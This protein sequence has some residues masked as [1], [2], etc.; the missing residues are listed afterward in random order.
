MAVKTYK[1]KNVQNK[2]VSEH[3]KYSEFFCPGSATLKLDPLLP[4]WL[5]ALIY[6]LGASKAVITSGYR[7]PDYSVKVGGSRTDRHTKGMAADVIFYDKAGKIIPPDTVCCTAEALGFIGGIAKI[8]ATATHIDTR[9]MSSKYWGDESKGST[10]SIWNQ[11]SGC[12]SFY[13]WFGKTRPKETMVTYK[14]RKTSVYRSAPF[15]LSAT[16]LGKLKKGAT[17]KVVKGGR[18]EYGGVTF[19]KVKIGNGYYWVNKR[20]LSK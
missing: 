12:T 11:R 17:V 20:C 8:G 5:E 19:Y 4:R 18:V 14:V 2:R 10:N 7:T 3:F 9:S 16:K 6:K 15:K 1:T 13:T